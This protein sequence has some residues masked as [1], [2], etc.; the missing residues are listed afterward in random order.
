MHDLTEPSKLWVSI[1]ET[2]SFVH[3]FGVKEMDNIG[4]GNN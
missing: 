2:L 1:S 3:F 4:E